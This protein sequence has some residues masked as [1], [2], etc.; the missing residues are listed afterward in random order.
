VAQGIDVDITRASAPATT[1]LP[2][3]RPRP[4]SSA[5][6]GVPGLY[7]NE[8]ARV[9]EAVLAEGPAIERMYL[10]GGLRCRIRYAGRAVESAVHRA[11]AHL[12]QPASVAAAGTGAPV[13]LDVGVWDETGARHLLPEPHPHMLVDYRNHCL[14]LCTDARYLALDERWLGT[15]SYVDREA[16]VAWACLGDARALP[17]Y[18][19]TAPLRSVLNALLVVRGRHLAH[20][21][22]VGTP[23]K[24]V[25]LTGAAGAGKSSTALACLSGSL[26][27]LADDFCG[28]QPGDP[29]R[30]FS[31]YAGAKL[32]R[33]GLARFPELRA[34][35]DGVERLDQEKAT[36]FVSEHFAGR[37]LAACPAAAILIPEVTGAARSAIVPAPSKDA[38]RAM[39]SW[40]I[41]QLAGCRRDSIEL[42]T[43]FC[44][45]L[46]AYHLRLGTDREEVRATL[47][48]FVAKL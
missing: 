27:Y 16:G 9:G 41:K 40:T 34:R 18:E 33:D 23:E 32:R 19:K 45:A 3:H 8:A 21:A 20:A 5:F 31:V 37:M 1:P 44:A 35:V 17:Y 47:E 11:L 28:V 4:T 6:R 14:E 39:V 43:R 36:T 24:G 13:D 2:E 7:F 22:A 38:W 25:L 30:I 26:R 15:R 48:D 10:L 29:P 46:P 12:E 42:L